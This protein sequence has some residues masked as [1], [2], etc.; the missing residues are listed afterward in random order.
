MERHVLHGPQTDPLMLRAF[1]FE[2]SNRVHRLVELGGTG[3]SAWE[4]EW[5]GL[6]FKLTARKDLVLPKGSEVEHPEVLRWVVDL[7]YQTDT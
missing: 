1:P 4:K 3:R 5:L 7:R 2:V 6:L